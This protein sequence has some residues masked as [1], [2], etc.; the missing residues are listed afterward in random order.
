MTEMMRA[1]AAAERWV[2]AEPVPETQVTSEAHQTPAPAQRH[3]SGEIVPV[4]PR[5]AEPAGQTVN[6]PP[7]V[8][9]DNIEVEIV[10]PPDSAQPRMAPRMA[11]VK[12]SP[13]PVMPF[14][15]RQR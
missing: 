4:L 10:A 11:P 2:A 12:V 13:K 3:G 5:S 6:V 15:W 8:V 9:I 14:G 1:L 7:Q